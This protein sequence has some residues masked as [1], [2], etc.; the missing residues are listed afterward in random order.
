MFFENITA[1]V[2][3]YYILYGVTGT[4]S[5]IAAAYM[6]LRRGNAFAADVTPPVRL[7]RWAASFF[8]AAMLSHLWWLLFYNISGEVLSVAHIVTAVIDCTTLMTTIAGTLLAMLQ[9]RKRPVWPVPVG[10]I[11]F[12]AL[13]VAIIVF[14]STQL[15]RIAIAYLLTAYLLFTIYMIY[16]VRQYGR[17]LCDNYADLENKR[18]W[19]SQ[20]LIIGIMLL[21]ILYTFDDSLMTVRYIMTTIELILFGLLLWRVE[22]LPQLSDPPTTQTCDPPVAEDTD[23]TCEVQQ[24]EPAP[25]A[26]T[27]SGIDF[28]AVEQMLDKRCVATQLYLQ[29]DL[30]L[31]QLAKAL[32]SN[33]TYLSQYFSSQGTTY[34]AYI[35]DL[36][37]RHFISRYREALSSNQPVTAQ[38]LAKE[39]GY[40]SYSTFSLAFKQRTGQSV[41]A[42]MHQTERSE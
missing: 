24:E 5:F 39:S 37:I 22:T 30:T 34:N 11:P 35:N 21:F 36:R 3:L 23:D 31:L 33:R 42:W 2:M 38:Q 20:V 14:Q 41:T 29:H 32:G 8:V 28:S 26:G 13:G 9:D 12:A 1:E 40:R 27:A 4:A 15:M 6:L 16:A 7:R 19:L 17:W 18:V 25:S 10:M